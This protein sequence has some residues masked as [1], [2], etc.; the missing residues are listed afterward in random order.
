MEMA[1]EVSGMILTHQTAV[2][3]MEVVAGVEMAAE[4]GAIE[5]HPQ[6]GTKKPP[7]SVGGSL[8]L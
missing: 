2:A 4:A 6:Q 3:A 5:S 7:I 1:G 8:K